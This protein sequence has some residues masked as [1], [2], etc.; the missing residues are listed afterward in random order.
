MEKMIQKL[1]CLLI[2]IASLNSFGQTNVKLNQ[3]NSIESSIEQ[4]NENRECIS[5]QEYR[6]IEQICSKATRD[7]ESSHKVG[8]RLA[9]VSLNWPLQAASGFNDCSFYYVAAYVDQNN[10][11]G[12]FSDYNCG[13]NTYDGHKGTDIA[14]GPFPFY[15]MDNSQVEV[16]A[17]AAGT[18]IAKHDGEYDRNCVGS[19]SALTANS[20]IIQHSDGSY[21]LYWHM[22]ANSLTS[23]TVN[24]TVAAGEYLGVVGSSGSSGGPHLH[25][26]V[27][28]GSTQSTMNDPFSGTCNTINPNSWWASQ[29]PYTEPGVI[30]SSVHTTDVVLPACPATE[31]PN[32]S[33][34]FTIP[35]Q[36]LGLAPGYAKFY[37]YVRNSTSGGVTSMSILNPNNS[38]FNSWNY[39]ITTSS[40]LSILGFSKLLP[41]VPG[42]YTFRAVYNGI[43]C[44][45][46]FDIVDVTSNVNM[47]SEIGLIE[48][49]PNPTSDGLVHL[50]SEVKFNILEIYN[51]I[52]EKLETIRGRQLDI[53]LPDF[54]GLYFIRIIDEKGRSTCRK[55]IRN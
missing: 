27:W 35:F 39:T 44:D 24:Q 20:L 54:R 7:F 37:A 41:T 50:N 55:I 10:A 8:S 48:L 53:Q 26:E 16:I 38:V 46:S 42:T 4:L 12:A 6:S 19:G 18:I 13:S 34:S 2:T 32:E 23:K 30:K 51:S 36:G 43:T 21:A 45:Q 11:T 40:R 29:K 9:T 47:N 14:I 49:F 28:A 22:K 17:A 3:V 33:T 1:G 5:E 25:F 31:T 52:G 15:K